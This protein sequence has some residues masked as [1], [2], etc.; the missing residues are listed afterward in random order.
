MT[1]HKKLVTR[2]MPERAPALREVREAVDELARLRK[3]IALR[4]GALPILD[5]D[6]RKAIRQG[7]R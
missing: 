7:H 6:I 2:P 4:R 5:Q 1:K 3:E